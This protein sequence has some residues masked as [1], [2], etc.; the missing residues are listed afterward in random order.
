MDSSDRNKLI[1]A[2]FRIMRACKHNKTI[3][4]NESNGHWKLLDR[5]TSVSAMNK[6]I[7]SLR[8]DEK[9]IFETEK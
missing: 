4:V 7:K 3:T 5:Y 9:T 1:K 2:G 6:A 8:G